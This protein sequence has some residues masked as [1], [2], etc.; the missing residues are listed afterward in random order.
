MARTRQQQGTGAPRRARAAGGSTTISASVA[1]PLAERLEAFVRRTQWQQSRVVANALEL[2][3]ELQPVA[4]QRMTEL[5]DRLGEARLRK[6]VAHAIERAIDRLE[7]NVVADDTARELAGGLPAE[8]SEEE[9]VRHTEA[10]IV[11][12]RTARRAERA[13]ERETRPGARR[14]GTSRQP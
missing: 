8:M 11:A 6:A 4:L 5:G 1:A 10:A 2:Y 14:R 12:S 7:W 3:M 13:A 9:L